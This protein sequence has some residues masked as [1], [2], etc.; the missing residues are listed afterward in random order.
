MYF[1]QVVVMTTRIQW[2]SY[3]SLV[4][5]QNMTTYVNAIQKEIE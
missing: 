5:A 1:K 4:D 2:E 3:W